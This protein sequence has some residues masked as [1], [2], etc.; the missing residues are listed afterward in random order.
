MQSMVHAE[1]ARRIAHLQVDL[2]I[3]QCPPEPL[4]LVIGQRKRYRTVLEKPL[5]ASS[6]RGSQ[7]ISS[8]RSVVHTTA[9][10]EPSP[11]LP[12][13]ACCP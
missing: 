4:L 9:T 11:T 6:T 13:H 8:Q 10:A 1:R 3:Q 12:D 2:G 5:G 7:R